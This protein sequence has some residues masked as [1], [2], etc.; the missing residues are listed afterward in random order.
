MSGKNK[1]LTHYVRQKRSRRA[2]CASYVA[3]VGNLAS[4]LFKLSLAL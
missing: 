2:I 4:Y 3:R 1:P